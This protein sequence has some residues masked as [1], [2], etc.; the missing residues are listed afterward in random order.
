[1]EHREILD[2][3]AK[4]TNYDPNQSTF[5][6]AN[7]SYELHKVNERIKSIIQLYDRTGALAVIQAKIMFKFILKKTSFN[8]LRYMQNP[9]ALDEDKEMWDMFHS[10]EVIAAENTY[11]EAINKL[12]D[13]VIGKTLIG[14]RNDEQ[15][16]DGLFEATDI[17][18]KSLEGCNKDLFIKGGRILPIT[19][20]STHI[21]LFETLAQCL[22]AFE[23]AEDGLYLVYINCGGTADGYFGFLLRN[24]SNLLFINERINEAY[25]GQHQNTRNN[26]WAENKKYELFPYDFIFNY[27]EH[28]YKG[29]ATKH[30]INEDKL[31]FFE[32]GP[33][34]Y[35]P[36]IIAMIMLSKQYI[37]E[38][39]DLPIKYI[40]ILLP[41]N[42]NKIPADTENALIL[43][44]NSALIASHKAIDLSF[45]LKKIMSGEYAEEF[46]H[47]SNK[48]YRETGHFTNRNQ[49]LVDH[50]G[51]GFSYDPATLYE[52]NTV[53][54]LTNSAS[55]SEEIPPEFIGTRDRIRLQGY[56]QIRKQLADYI[57]DRI[58]DAW[59]AYGKTPAVIDW[60]ISN[61]KN[62]FEKIEMLVAAEYLRIKEGG[63]AL[64]QSWRWGDSQKIDIYY[65]EQKYPAVYRSIILNK[66]KKNGRYYSNEYL[67]NHSG[68]I[69]NLFFTFA[70]K[71]WTQLELLCG[72]EVP[73]IVKGWLERGHRGDGNSILDA[74]DLVTEVGTP[75]EERESEKYE[76]LYGDSNVYFNF[77]F[78]IG[79]SK[80]GLNQ[81]LKKYGVSKR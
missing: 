66:E 14:E 56:Y 40:D 39:L 15:V 2:K 41:S 19:K 26:R 63:E 10:S 16:L 25:S 52:T 9:G 7:Y 31:A 54:R 13:E 76:S 29:Y 81:I 74:T 20:I 23:V 17:V 8:M 62:N 53:L 57:R 46:H 77:A 71:D 47:N 59:V 35:L 32:L 4:Y 79:Y 73:K 24:N 11:I 36:I 50:W 70:P 37:G 45:D 61:I 43:P 60:Y 58:H 48:D 1:M 42:I 30:L 28:D 55:D 6:L 3:W 21:H 68:A 72:S 69:C 64:G 44:E 33:K 38:T 34:A 75:F 12:S 80:R 65:K 27:T 49:L 22:T 5:N 51:Q 78:S 67:C 18:M